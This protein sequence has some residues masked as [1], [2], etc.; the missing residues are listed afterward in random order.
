MSRLDNDIVDVEEREPVC[1]RRVGLVSQMGP[2]IGDAVCASKTKNSRTA[3]ELLKR[4][5]RRS[6]SE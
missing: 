1:S 4:E 2:E 6:L 5:D 3:G